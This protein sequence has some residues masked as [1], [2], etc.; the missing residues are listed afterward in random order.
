MPVTPFARNARAVYEGYAVS[1]ARRG[2]TR[3][4]S[5]TVVLRHM[6]WAVDA[7]DLHDPMSAPTTPSDDVLALVVGLAIM[8]LNV[9]ASVPLQDYVP[10]RAIHDAASCAAAFSDW[11]AAAEDW[12]MQEQILRAG[13]SDASAS[14][15]DNGSSVSSGDDNASNPDQSFSND[16][17]D[18]FRAAHAE[19]IA[20][21]LISD[22]DSEP[23]RKR[24]RSNG[25]DGNSSADDDD[26]SSAASDD[27]NDVD[28]QY[29]S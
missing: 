20:E 27:S 21:G 8:G 18:A 13:E 7:E 12:G 1:F 29:A 4:E 26:S 6:W 16:A 3:R 11:A 2:V 22:P 17:V 25:D 9:T 24:R 28:A 14:N 15:G 19:D 10:S 5:L 23:R